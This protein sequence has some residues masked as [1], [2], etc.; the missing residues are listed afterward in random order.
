MSVRQGTLQNLGVI[1]S[2]GIASVALAGVLRLT[3]AF[4]DAKAQPK[5]D[6]TEVIEPGTKLAKYNSNASPECVRK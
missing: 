2:W 6:C 1:V 5:T 3:G 4:D